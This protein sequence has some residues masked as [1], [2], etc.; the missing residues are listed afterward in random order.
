MKHQTSAAPP[1]ESRDKLKS[2][3]KNGLL[4]DEKDFACLIDSLVHRDDLAPAPPPPP[5]PEPAPA[6]VD[7]GMPVGMRIGTF[8]PKG[9]YATKL[10][11]SS[12]LQPD[13]RAPADGNWYPVLSELN[14]CYAFEIVA[15]ASGLVSSGWHAVT[16]A[17]ALT[18]F[19]QRASVRQSFSSGP[20]TKPWWLF[21]CLRRRRRG[22]RVEFKW[23][24]AGGTVSLLV[25]SNADFGKDQDGAQ[26]MIDYHM[27]RLW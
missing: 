21:P 5:V 8:S 16:H 22:N 20:E 10:L 19:S 26:V 13:C 6:P 9:K 25:R 2:R 12:A 24:R 18:S 15:C 4:P 14:D 27:T 1:I 23:Y 17:I 7:D 11:P 3:F